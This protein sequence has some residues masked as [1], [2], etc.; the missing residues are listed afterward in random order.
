MF[1]S[2]SSDTSRLS[3]DHTP[4]R[5][6]GAEPPGPPGS[7]TGSS[8]TIDVRGSPG[9]AGSNHSTGRRWER[10]SSAS[11]VAE[12]AATRLRPADRFGASSP[13]PPPI[14]SRND[15]PAPEKASTSA[16]SASSRA[17]ATTGTADAP[18]PALSR[19]MS[20]AGA[21][22]APSSMESGI[23]AR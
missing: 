7:R 21:R 18:H 13:V 14:R 19:T 9:P 17:S 2:H 11:S 1:V 3:G 8:A 20:T 15:S 4:A 5:V 12:P 10:A 22:A 6:S 16:G 23:A